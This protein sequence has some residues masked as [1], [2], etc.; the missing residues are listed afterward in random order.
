MLAVFPIQ[1]DLAHVTSLIF[2]S[3]RVLELLFFFQ[4]LWPS[5]ELFSEPIALSLTAAIEQSS[6]HCKCVVFT[7]VFVALP[8]DGDSILENSLIYFPEESSHPF[9]LYL[10]SCILAH[11]FV[12][13]SVLDLLLSPQIWLS[14]YWKFQSHKAIQHCQILISHTPVKVDIRNSSYDSLI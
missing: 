11:S 3:L 4:W 10:H 5:V 7:T 12:L 14:Q 9:I 13:F 6:F 1:K 2:F 8:L